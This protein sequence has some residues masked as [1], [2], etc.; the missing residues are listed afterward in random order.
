[1]AASA[2]TGSEWSGKAHRP[3]VAPDLLNFELAIFPLAGKTLNRR[4]FAGDLPHIC[5]RCSFM[6]FCPLRV[7]DPALVQNLL[8]SVDVYFSQWIYPQP[9]VMPAW[10]N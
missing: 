8:V 9:L 10:S 4:A 1:M 7:V 3:Q 6:S 2:Q 5:P